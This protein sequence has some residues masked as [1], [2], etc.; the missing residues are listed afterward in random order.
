M[1]NV[2]RFS[3]LILFIILT[4]PLTAR[5]EDVVVA[6]LFTSPTCPAC[7]AAEKIMQEIAQKQNVIALSCNVAFNRMVQ[8]GNAETALCMGRQKSYTS[9]I[10]QSTRTY[11]PQMV[12]N[13][14][15]AMVGAHRNGVMSA[16]SEDAADGVREVALEVKNNRLM[17]DYP[18][19]GTSGL[20]NIVLIATQDTYMPPV[21]RR[22]GF[23]GFTNGVRMISPLSAWDG[24]ALMM[25]IP[26]PSGLSSADQLVLLAQDSRTQKI[27]AAGKLRL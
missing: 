19:L 22:G 13:G 6:E 12:V 21:A 10:L 24:K 26:M 27:I 23:H 7:P 17:I 16:L 5:A 20:N 1:V 14:R 11:T 2:M 9:S 8:T 25:S 4:L 18:A 3:L 15:N